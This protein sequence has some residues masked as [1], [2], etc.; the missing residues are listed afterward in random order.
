MPEIPISQQLTSSRI[1]IGWPRT[2]FALVVVL[3]ILLAAVHLM[4]ATYSRTL[5]SRSAELEREIQDLAGIIP[6]GD[7]ERL[8]KLDQ[9]IRNLH[10][11]LDE[12]VYLSLLLDEL[13]RLTLPQVR[14]IILGVHLENAAVA[15][16]GVAPSMAAASL[17]AEAFAQSQFIREVTVNSVSVA[18]GRGGGVT[19]DIDLSFD[20]A[21]VQPH[22]R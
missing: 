19:F 9:Q 20:R 13:E 6:P 5:V 8:I 21:L 12:R 17:Q 1:V 7:L 14:Y 10:L 16:R 15:L 11:L 2:L 4:I 3:I 18:A 22:A